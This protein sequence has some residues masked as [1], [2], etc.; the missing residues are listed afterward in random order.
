MTPL[1][2]TPDD[3]AAVTDLLQKCGLP[4]QDLV[5]GDMR[6]FLVIPA[7]GELAACA[8]LQVFGAVG[9]LRSLAVRPPLRLQGVGGLLCGMIEQRARE[10]GVHTLHLLTTSAEKYFARRGYVRCAREQLPAA[11]R[12]TA[13]FSSLCPASAACMCRK[14]A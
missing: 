11:I 5:P 4:H 9:L 1:P 13:E 6:E 14:L 7:E 10:S 8:G 3:L 2:A 12:A